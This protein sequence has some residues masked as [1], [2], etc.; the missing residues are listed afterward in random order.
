MKNHPEFPFM[1]TVPVLAPQLLKL[2][3]AAARLICPGEPLPGHIVIPSGPQSPARPNNFRGRP[4]GGSPNISAP[5]TDIRQGLLNFPVAPRNERAGSPQRIRAVVR[6][7][8]EEPR[9]N[10]L[11][12]RAARMHA[13]PARPDRNNESDSTRKRVRGDGQRPGSSKSA[14]KPINQPQQ[15]KCS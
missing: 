7:G 13:Q 2:R 6:S 15:R 10:Q 14:G 5:V 8:T 12:R 1:A 4:K 11:P 9:G 3:D